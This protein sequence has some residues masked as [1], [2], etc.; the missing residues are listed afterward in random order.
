MWFVYLQWS[1]PLDNKCLDHFRERVLA[2]KP[3]EELHRSFCETQWIELYCSLSGVNLTVFF[4]LGVQY[5]NATWK[6]SNEAVLL[7][8]IQCLSSTKNL[9]VLTK[10]T[11]T[12]NLKVDILKRAKAWVYRFQQTSLYLMRIRL[13]GK[14]CHIQSQLNCVHEKL[15]CLYWLFYFDAGK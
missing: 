3:P 13:V 14:E 1:I 6:K 7:P 2:L 9:T 15:G 12:V 8:Q 10:K 5:Y 4:S 11:K